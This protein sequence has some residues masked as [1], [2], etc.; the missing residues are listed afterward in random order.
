LAIKRAASAAL[1]FVGGAL[2]QSDSKID[3]A[4]LG[5]EYQF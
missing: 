3:L 4:T 5:V 1:F 2:G